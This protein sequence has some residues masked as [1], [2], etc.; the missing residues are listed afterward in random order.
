MKTINRMFK[1]QQDIM[2]VLLDDKTQK[3]FRYQVL[4]LI[5][6]HFKIQ[7]LAFVIHDNKIEEIGCKSSLDNIT[8]GIS[9]K[10]VSEYYSKYQKHDPFCLSESNEDIVSLFDLVDEKDFLCSKYYKEFYSQSP[11]YYQ[12][13]GY[14]SDHYGNQIAHISFG[15][16]KEEGPF[17]KN[18][19][20]MISEIIKIVRIE[21][22]KGLQFK[23]VNLENR[24][25]RNQNEIFPIGQIIMD[26]NY[27]ICSYNKIALEFIQELTG[28]SI[29]YFK[30]FFINEILGDANLINDIDNL[31]IENGDFIFKIVFKQNLDDNAT[32][33]RINYVIYIVRKITPRHKH[34]ANFDKLSQREREVTNLIRMGYSNK[35]IADVLKISPFTVKSH[36]QKI[37]VKCDSSNRIQLINKLYIEE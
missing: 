19:I 14:I 24:I 31:L 12:T 32:I 9:D 1:F 16:T 7:Y 8:L 3:R 13:V 27:S 17:T 4:L 28:V 26:V 15:R 30:Y 37:F 2:G 23:E 35:E 34:N 25:L 21:F 6:K 33:H 10:M 5:K 20:L 29:N 18:D 11:I 36:I 22:L